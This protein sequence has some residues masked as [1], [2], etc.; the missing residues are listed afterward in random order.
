MVSSLSVGSKAIQ[1]KMAEVNA[2]LNASIS[3]KTKSTIKDLP[4]NSQRL[5]PS[6]HQQLCSA[7]NSLKANAQTPFTDK[8]MTLSNTAP[9]QTQSTTDHR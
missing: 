5:A 6:P 3:T 1:F 4:T 7:S 2:K 9:Q 8:Q